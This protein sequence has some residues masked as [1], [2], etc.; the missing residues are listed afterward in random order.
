MWVAG[1]AGEKTSSTEKSP[2]VSEETLREGKYLF[3]K[4]CNVC[5][6]EGGNVINPEKT[7]H[8]EHLKK[9]GITTPEDIVKIMRDPGPGMRTFGEDKISDE[10]AK[11]IAY[12]ILN[13]FLDG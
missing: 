13:T 8:K 6:L 10:D 11:K 5:H 2:V 12:Y 1:P 7:L 4:N 9:H 3:L